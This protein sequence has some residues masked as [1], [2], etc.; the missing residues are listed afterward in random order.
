M[1]GDRKQRT[2]AE[3]GSVETGS[4]HGSE[5]SASWESPSR[6]ESL[7]EY[8]P[9]IIIAVDPQGDIQYINRVLPQYSKQAVLGS[10][11]SDYLPPSH[12][13]EMSDALEA[14]LADGVSRT[15]EVP[16][17]GP[18]GTHLW[19]SS[20]IGP[21]RD[22]ENI[23]G[24]VIVSQ[25]V[26]E[27]K[28]AQNELLA[29]R[30]LAVLGTMAAGVAH[31]INTPVQYLGDS[32]RFLRDAGDDLLKLIECLHTLRA[33]V[34]AGTPVEEAI[35][36][37]REA[38]EE[39]DLPFLV[40][41]IPAACE[42]CLDGLNRVATIVRSLKEFAHPSGK[43]MAVADLNRAIASTLTIAANEYK[44]VAEVVADY[45]ELP[46]MV[47]HI[48]EIN[49]VVLNIVVNAAHAIADAR[50]DGD[51]KGT[52]TVRTRQDGDHVVLSIGDTG[53][54]IPASI[55]GRIFDPFFTTK[56]VGRGTGQGLAIA[57]T[58]VKEQ[59]GGDLTFQTVEGK[60]TTFFIRLPIAGKA[61]C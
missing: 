46:P 23:V 11:W 40:E 28:R 27:W 26:T 17:L 34:E 25:D 10:H 9:A 53:G 51:P 14:V 59:H 49:Q 35:A 30:R 2:T 4:V 36:K 32:L 56:E 19:F 37:A 13:S 45:G 47:C 50:K 57:W 21:I 43:E 61:A 38:E 22:G 5:I 52:I 31:E 7:L 41:N 42:R 18:D 20:Q 15:Y 6:L 39:A 44:Y 55:Q 8:A 54:G 24:A 58:I 1:A 29:A 12:R 16:I 3:S 48:G 60:G 33:A